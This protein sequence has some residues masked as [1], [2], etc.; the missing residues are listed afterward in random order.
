MC[1][2]ECL[3]IYVEK[4]PDLDDRAAASEHRGCLLE[5]ARKPGGVDHEGPLLRR[6]SL[7]HFARRGIARRE[8]NRAD[9]ANGQLAAA[10]GGV[11]HQQL[12]RAHQRRLDGM[13]KSE[14]ADPDDHDG[15]AG[16]EPRRPRRL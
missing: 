2:V 12:S 3:T 7:A 6:G 8:R 9:D 16:A 13:R 14:R 5:C 11:K 15:V 10:R 4:R 1:R